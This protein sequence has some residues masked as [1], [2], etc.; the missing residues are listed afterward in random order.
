M[1]LLIK[2]GLWLEEDKVCLGQRLFNSLMT[3]QVD[4]R[5]MAFFEI[6]N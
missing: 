4:G 5:A 6:I 3:G 2:D 1:E